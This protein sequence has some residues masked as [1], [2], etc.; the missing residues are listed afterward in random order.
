MTAALQSMG[1]P[2]LD[3][4]GNYWHAQDEAGQILDRRTGKP[5]AAFTAHT[6]RHPHM[7]QGQPHVLL[8]SV[9]DPVTFAARMAPEEARA[10]AASLVQAAER[11]EALRDAMCLQP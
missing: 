11:A 2:K 7:V 8:E 4:H 5:V 3:R 6:Q 10:L 9:R 1:R